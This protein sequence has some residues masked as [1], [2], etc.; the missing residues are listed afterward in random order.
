MAVIE[1][2]LWTMIEFIFNL[3]VSMVNKELK[4]SFLDRR[5]YW[6]NVL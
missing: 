3:E 6:K 4:Y 5:V 1:I 2:N